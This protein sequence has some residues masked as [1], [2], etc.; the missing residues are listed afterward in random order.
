[1]LRPEGP[2]FFAGEHLSYVPFWQEGAA[3]SAHAAMTELRSGNEALAEARHNRESARSL[4]T[5]VSYGQR[6]PESLDRLRATFAQE[7]I[8]P[9]F[10][11]HYEPS[12]PFAC[13]RQN[14]GLSD[15]F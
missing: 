3:L 4:F 6:D 11:S 10:L 8:P 13:L 15:K 1:M 9:E 5:L 2:I 7:G 12:L 14:D